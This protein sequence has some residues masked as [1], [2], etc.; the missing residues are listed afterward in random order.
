MSD[1][2][3]KPAGGPTPATP[4]TDSTSEIPDQGNSGGNNQ[5]D[6]DDQ[7]DQHDQDD[8]DDKGDT[9][10][11]KGKVTVTLY[12][13]FKNKNQDKDNRKE[14]KESSVFTY[15]KDEFLGG[16]LSSFLKAIVEEK[17]L[18]KS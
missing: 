5:N 16:T 9:T 18:G 4:P 11:D 17:H 13:V 15:E 10:L 7:H 1:N 8:Q 3:N 6:K 14:P 12:K 2:S